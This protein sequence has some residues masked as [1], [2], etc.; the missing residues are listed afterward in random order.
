MV[1][2]IKRVCA[3]G[4]R[5]LAVFALIIS[6][7]CDSTTTLPDRVDLEAPV[8]I[9]PL[10]RQATAAGKHLGF[11]W[12]GVDG[13]IGYEIEL[14]STGEAGREPMVVRV[15]RPSAVVRLGG[16]GPLAW[17]V[18][19]LE[20]EGRGGYWSQARELTVRQAE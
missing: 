6:S 15:V 20:A 1:G 2:S 3:V 5:G 10:P 4:V 12:S 7:G 16:P 17:R 13:A 19:A 14:R 18:R 8:L 11:R 9:S